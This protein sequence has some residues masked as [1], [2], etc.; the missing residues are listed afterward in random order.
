MPSEKFSTLL[1]S[2]NLSFVEKKTLFI[3]IVASA[4]F[5]RRNFK[6]NEDLHRYVSIYEN[7]FN[8]INVRTKE[9]GFAKYVYDSRPLLFSRIANKIYKL[10]DANKIN[11]LVSQ[12]FEFFK[13]K[14]TNNN[15]DERSKE[16][17]ST[18]ILAD[19][20]LNDDRNK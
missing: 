20:E 6:K 5:S 17:N 11:K 13:D 3:G 16:K 7:E 1:R 2:K 15:L 10:D 4:I 18:S 9:P 8:I 14:N 19:M 12:H